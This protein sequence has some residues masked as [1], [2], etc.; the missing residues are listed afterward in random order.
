MIEW[1]RLQL[2]AQELSKMGFD[3]TNSGASGSM[4]R[5]RQVGDVIRRVVS[6]SVP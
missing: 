5:I 1:R 2:Y 3:G 6:T 4:T